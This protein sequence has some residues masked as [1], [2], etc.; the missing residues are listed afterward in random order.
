MIN[1]RINIIKLCSIVLLSYLA[2]PVLASD[3]NEGFIAAESGNYQTAVSKWGPLA[4]AG[5]AAAQFNIALMYHGGLGVS[6]NEAEA[7]KWYKKSAN[8][9]FSAAQEFLSAAYEE[10]WFGLPRDKNLARFW[11]EKARLENY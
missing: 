6:L 4:S 11:E 8:N 7:V 3:Y 5:H 2:S 9:G 1:N 10:G